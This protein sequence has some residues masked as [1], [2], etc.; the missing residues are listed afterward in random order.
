MKVQNVRLQARV[1][2][3]HETNAVLFHRVDIEKRKNL[4]YHESLTKNKKII[5]KL[6]AKRSMWTIVA[7]LFVTLSVG[8]AL[9]LFC[10][11]CCCQK[12]SS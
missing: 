12:K 2:L 8:L 10:S 6:E 9:T 4:A 7:I 3:E 1:K 5:N 11:C